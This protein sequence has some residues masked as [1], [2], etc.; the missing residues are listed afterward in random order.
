[1]SHMATRDEVLTALDQMVADADKPIA[2]QQ[3]YYFAD[4]RADYEWACRMNAIVGNRIVVVPPA[5]R[6]WEGG[7]K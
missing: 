4:S 2:R 7:P 1:M 3:D 6:L 5:P